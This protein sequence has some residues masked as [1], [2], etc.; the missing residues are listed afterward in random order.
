MSIKETD[1]YEPIRLFLQERG[2]AV[3]A[4][5]NHCDVVAVREETTIV[6]ELKRNFNLKLVYQAIERQSLTEQVY[7]AIPRPE[8]GQNTHSW[9][10]MLRLLKRLELG[11]ITV[12]LDSPLQVVEVILEPD[13]S[14]IRKN[15]KKQD[16]LQKELAGRRIEANTGG[17]NRHKILTAYR[18]RA[19]ELC[20]M[21]ERWEQISLKALREMGKEKQYGNILRSNT[22][23]WFERVEK[24]VYTLTEAGKAALQ[25]KEHEKAVTFYRDLYRKENAE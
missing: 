9:L 10:D 21:M 19:L 8:K 16:R 14:P 1:L 7:V 3:Q 2:Y 6:I 22:Y 4:E 15:K 5:V 20:C 13:D 25:Q 24:G 17:M 23:H 11:L 12:A 18:E